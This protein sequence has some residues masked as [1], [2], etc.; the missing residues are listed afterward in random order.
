MK[1]SVALAKSLQP[2][3]F[4]VKIVIKAVSVVPVNFSQKYIGEKN[5][6][7]RALSNSI[8]ILGNAYPCLAA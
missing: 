1:K 7:L 3:S 4:L 5:V 2:E 6:I 8:G